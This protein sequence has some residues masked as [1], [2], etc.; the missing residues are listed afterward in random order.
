M[1]AK[2]K[3]KEAMWAGLSGSSSDKDNSNTGDKIIV[4]E[5]GSELISQLKNTDVRK[6]L[7]IKS[8]MT[9]VEIDK[10]F[11]LLK[12]IGLKDSDSDKSTN[13][14]HYMFQL[15]KKDTDTKAT[16]VL[17]LTLNEGHSFVTTQ[18]VTDAGLY[19]SIQLLEIVN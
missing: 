10:D 1:K 6:S 11:V 8:D 4:A 17:K 13:P 18:L 5:V 9:V 2:F 15:E 19:Y 12:M 3:I 7:G 14:A 16:K